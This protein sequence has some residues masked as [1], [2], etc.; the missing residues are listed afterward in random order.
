MLSVRS[1]TEAGPHPEASPPPPAPHLCVPQE[2]AFR[3]EETGPGL[4]ITGAGRARQFHKEERRPQRHRDSV[5]TGMTSHHP[6]CSLSA[7]MLILWAS[8]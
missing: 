4:K 1:S 6:A 8:M 3:K 7:L 2:G 5:S